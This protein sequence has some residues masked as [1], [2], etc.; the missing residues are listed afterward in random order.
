[1]QVDAQREPAWLFSVRVADRPGALAAVASVFAHR[2]VSVT[3]VVGQDAADDPE[4]R[5]TV[6]V[7]FRATEKRKQELQRV[8]RRL[9]RVFAV[10][11][12]PYEDPML[13]ETAL[14]RARPGEP[15]DHEPP[16]G[17]T[18]E[19]VGRRDDAD[20]FI[21][22]GPP[23]AVDAWLATLRET[24]ALHGAVAATIAV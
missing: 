3:S 8:L 4:G 23:A 2:G 1:M 13:R 11:D 21:V 18:V 14:V 7:T 9:P 5:G 10:T 15:L 22:V 20:V 12:Y 19:R 24:G 16:S 17:I 6:V